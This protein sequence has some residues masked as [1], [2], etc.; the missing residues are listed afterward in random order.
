MTGTPLPDAPYPHRDA[1]DAA[2]VRRLIATQFPG[3]ADLPVEAVVPGGWDNRTFRL[4]NNLSVRLPSGPGYAASVAKEQRWLPA[5]APAL[6][7]PIPAPLAQG[8]PTPDYPWAWSVYRWIEGEPALTAAIPDRVQFATDL[9]AFLLALQ[10]IDASDGP[11]AGAHNYW[12]GGPL[13]VYD[14]ETRQTLETLAGAID[15]AA[16]QEIWETALATQWEAAPVWVHGD[17]AVG[18]LLAA[19]GRLS[20]VIDFGTSGVG[21]PACDLVMAWTF[22][23]GESR[24]T[25][26]AAL[27][28]DD[29]TWARA[30][31]WALWKALITIAEPEN[32][33]APDARRVLA[34]VLAAPL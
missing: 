18:N 17:V 13:A 8:Q 23:T 32:P 26:R 29:A 5:L 7:L 25:F 10:Q 2:L 31:G 16:A 20:A 12:R 9:A 28:L 4:G 15:V 3:W 14:A 22:F 19:D 33:H 1:I 21:D 6:P 24:R 11:A 27:P 34:E 30:R